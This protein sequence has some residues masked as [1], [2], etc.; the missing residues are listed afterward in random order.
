MRILPLPEQLFKTAA[1]AGLAGLTFALAGCAN[2]DTMATGSISDDYR[3]RHPIVVTDV[4]HNLDL[5]VAPGESKLTI[6]MADTLTGFAQDYRNA[7]TGYVQMMLPR[8]APNTQA[9]ATLARQIRS[10]LAAKGVPSPKIIERYYQAGPSG[11]AAPIRL[12][13]TATTAVAGP[14]G[15][16]P[17]DL[18]NDTSDNRNWH[19]FGCSSQAN[20]AAQV[21]SPTDL[22]RP[23]GMTPIDAERRSTVISDYRSGTDTSTTSSSSSSD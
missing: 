2:R 23:R 13:Y 8:G 7:S 19:N 20:L 5:P 6:G 3:A 18:S 4:E 21:A 10:H 15:Q 1:L 16:W 14:C 11:D 17:E 22:I 9:A 12:S